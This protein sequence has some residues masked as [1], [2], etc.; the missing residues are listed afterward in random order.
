MPACPVVLQY[1]SLIIFSYSSEISAWALPVWPAFDDVGRNKF[2][3]L[4]QKAK[5][6]CILYSS[7]L[8]KSV[9]AQ[10]FL[11]VIFNFPINPFRKVLNTNFLQTFEGKST[12]FHCWL[13]VGKLNFYLC[14]NLHLIVLELSQDLGLKWTEWEVAVR[15]T[16]ELFLLI[17][18]SIFN[19]N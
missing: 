16:N 13:I 8:G 3:C 9:A 15:F 1:R 4:I 12:C 7:F 14:D 17:Y 5:S 10:Y 11:E 18:S 19:L 6:I 2:C